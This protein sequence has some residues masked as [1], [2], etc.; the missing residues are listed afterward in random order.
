MPNY[1]QRWIW[2]LK[3]VNAAYQGLGRLVQRKTVMSIGG[4]PENYPIALTKDPVN[5]E[6]FLVEGDSAG[7]NWLKQRK[8][9]GLFKAILPLRGKD[10]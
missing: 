1:F 4:L 2:R 3:P 7:G 6:V 9:I 10:S 5:C 8:G